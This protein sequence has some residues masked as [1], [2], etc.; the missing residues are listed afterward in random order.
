[1]KKFHDPS[2]IFATTPAV[3][4]IS[5]P[6]ISLPAASAS[7][8][9]VY[10]VSTSATYDIGFSG[11]GPGYFGPVAA[12]ASY[13]VAAVGGGTTTAA[14]SAKARPSNSEIMEA[15]SGGLK[16][17]GALTEGLTARDAANV[18]ADFLELQARQEEIAR[19]R[20]Q[21][22]L[23]KERNRFLAR[24]RAAFAAQGA[25]TTSG[26]AGAVLSSQ[27][28]EYAEK[29]RRLLADSLLR[30]GTLRAKAS[31][32]RRSGANAFRSA[33]FGAGQQFFS[34]ATSL[35]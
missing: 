33:V 19:F 32:A 12:P 31:N 4:Q 17:I 35:L 24:S 15:I 8:A 1:M 10:D 29:N 13:N 25:D 26:S 28:G 23:K 2:S 14:E 30:A 22:D 34:A 18:E 20:E 9:P 11:V 16:S 21:R 27:R 7:A 3:S 5:G 6:A